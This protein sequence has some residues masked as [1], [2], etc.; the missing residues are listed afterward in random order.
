[1]PHGDIYHLIAF[2]LLSSV[3]SNIISSKAGALFVLP[4]AASTAEL[5]GVSLLPFVFSI[6][7][8]ASMAV[9]SPLTYPSNLMVYGPGGYVFQD[10]LRLGLPITIITGTVGIVMINILVPF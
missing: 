2:F 4:I 3:A 1:M 9:S 8:G 7:V 10:Y 6:M 5:L